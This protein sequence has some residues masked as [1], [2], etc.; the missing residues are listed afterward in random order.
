[1]PY[2][3][4]YNELEEYHAGMWKKVS[5]DEFERLLPMAIRFT[6]THLLYGKWMLK[7]LDLWPKSCNQNLS[8]S[9]INHQAFIGHA[10]TCIAIGC[11]EYITRLAWH[12]LSQHQ[13][14]LANEQADIAINVWKNKQTT[15]E[16]QL[17]LKLVWE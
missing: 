8:D 14:D 10:A 16:E 17:C 2:Y 4:H 12:E 1:M 13:Q 6:G 3:Y 7:A 5:K 15:R 9:G 11:P